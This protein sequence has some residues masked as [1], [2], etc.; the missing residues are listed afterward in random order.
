LGDLDRRMLDWGLRGRL[1]VLLLLTKADKLKKGA[2]RATQLAV[3]RAV[4]NLSGR[5]HVLCFS[6]PQ[7]Q[8][9]AAVQGLLDRWLEVD[10][11]AVSGTS[12]EPARSA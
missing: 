9:V 5:I 12:P 8:G 6:A 11:G 3:E 10:L 2:A 1:P 4:A 7:R